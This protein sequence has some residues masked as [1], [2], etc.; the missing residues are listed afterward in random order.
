LITINSLTNKAYHSA[1]LRVD[2]KY[3][4]KKTTLDFFLDITNFYGAKSVA[5][6]FYVFSA[7][8]D[9]TFKTTDANLLKK[10]G[11]NAIPVL[12]DNNQIFITPTFGFIWEF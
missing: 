1:D 11:S 10:D 7:N 9:G 12:F 5:P 4:Y 2:K 6:P 3:N 8:T